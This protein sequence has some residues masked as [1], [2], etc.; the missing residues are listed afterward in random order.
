MG[1]RLK[2]AQVIIRIQSNIDD[3][4]VYVLIPPRYYEV[5]GLSDMIKS[6]VELSLFKTNDPDRDLI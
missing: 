5:E 6:A 4:D 2:G 3:L 1:K